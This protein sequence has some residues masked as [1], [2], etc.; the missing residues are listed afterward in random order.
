M[1][2]GGLGDFH[3]PITTSSAEAQKYFDQGLRLAWAFNHD[4]ATRS[5][6]K[7]R[8]NRSQLRHLFLGR[9]P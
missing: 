7:G 2:F 9:V 3:R 1:L 8:R 4:E 6:A 5:F